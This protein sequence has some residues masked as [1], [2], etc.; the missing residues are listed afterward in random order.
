MGIPPNLMNFLNKLKTL[1][2]RIEKKTACDEECRKSN[3]LE[4]LKKELDHSIIHD[5]E[6]YLNEAENNYYKFRDGEIENDKRFIQ[7]YNEIGDKQKKEYIEKKNILL[8]N[9]NKFKK[10]LLSFNASI[11][12]IDNVINFT[13][14]NNKKLKREIDEIKS[15]ININD[16]KF[17]Y[18][19]QYLK[20]KSYIK[21]FLT[22]LYIL[23]CLVYLYL[24]DIKNEFFDN[25]LQ[26]ISKISLM[27]LYIIIINNIF[28]YI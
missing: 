18:K 12:N 15:N 17:Y 26:Y 24:S 6:K 20:F 5:N 23:F 19:K 3:R 9:I 13:N 1:I 8:D 22:I 27:I 14:N 21:Y 16:R 28:Y 10:N 4:K 11:D 25:K 2:S 7:K